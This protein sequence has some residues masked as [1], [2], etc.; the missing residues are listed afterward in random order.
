MRL[1]ERRHLKA[2]LL[3]REYVTLL[4]TFSGYL[5]IC[6]WAAIRALQGLTL[7]QPDLVWQLQLRQLMF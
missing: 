1:I 4:P 3:F 2:I 6:S 7:S 5:V